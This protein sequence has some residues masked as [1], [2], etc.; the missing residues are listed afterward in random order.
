M[1]KLANLLFT[2][3][4]TRRN[5]NADILV[6]SAHPGYADT[7]LVAKG[8][9]MNSSNGTLSLLNRINRTLGQP[10]EM[11]ALP[12]LYAATAANVS[13]GGYYGPSGF[14]RM[15]GWPAPEIPDA[16]R[17]TPEV[18]AQLWDVSQ[19]LTGVRFPLS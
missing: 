13:P 15:R 12:S 5:T 2:F 3:E 8:L 11:G 18:A 1:S 4:L 9:L 14:M 10:G 7:S 17:V 16:K 6:A 19:E